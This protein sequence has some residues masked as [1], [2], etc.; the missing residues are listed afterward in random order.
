[1]WALLGSL[2]VVLA[3]LLYAGVFLMT[4]GYAGA[5]PTGHQAVGLVVPL[6]MTLFAALLMAAAAAIVQ[7][8]GVPA[9]GAWGWAL[10]MASGAAVVALLV[11]W[12]D[13]RWPLLMPW[14]G[15]MV[16]AL[17][18][19]M[20]AL[21]LLRALWGAPALSEAWRGALWM[22]ILTST[23]AG[24]LCGGA[25][26]VRW[27][28]L[29]Q[30]NLARAQAAQ[31][32]RDAERARRTALGPVDRLREDFAQHSPDTPLWVYISGLPDIVDPAERDFTI[33]RALQV[34]DFNADL[35]RTMAEAHP[36]F[37]HGAAL[38]IQY[39]SQP[40]PAWAAM[41][42][43]AIRRT[44]DEL[45][46]EADWMAPDDMNNPDPVAHLDTLQAAAARYAPNA[47]LDTA[48]RQLDRAMAARLP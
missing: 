7:F 23:L 3:L 13:G 40:D 9:P 6:G 4:A 41:L 16:G 27:W 48:L 11:A 33:A 39:V 46:A 44:A 36:R 20:V 28:Q 32:E 31:A 45:T 14:I 17:T 29:E 10:L 30:E 2:A 21:F 22:L 1:M 38:L 25:L 34:P 26:M 18:P 5:V 42:A 8:R 37:R 35:A 19:T 47:E 24:L 12:M 15:F 43:Q